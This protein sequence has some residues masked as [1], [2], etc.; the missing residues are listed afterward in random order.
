MENGNAIVYA[1]MEERFVKIGKCANPPKVKI[2]LGRCK[3]FVNQ[4][5][6]KSNIKVS[7]K[8]L[9]QLFGKKPKYTYRTNKRRRA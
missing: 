9:A 8:T 7:K 1:Y 4:I 3:H 6:V 5:I 2:N